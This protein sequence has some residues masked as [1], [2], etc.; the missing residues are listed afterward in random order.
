[1]YVFLDSGFNQNKIES[2]KMG[3]ALHYLQSNMIV[4]VVFYQERPIA[5]EFPDIVIC[6]IIYTEPAIRGDTS[7]RALK[8]A[9]INTHLEINVPLF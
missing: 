7:S 6:K 3:K 9:K 1:M 8:S 4:D 5:I 2:Q